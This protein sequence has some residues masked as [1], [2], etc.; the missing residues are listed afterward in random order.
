MFYAPEFFHAHFLRCRWKI[1]TFAPS[2]YRSM[3]DT[4]YKVAGHVFALCMENESSVS[5]NDMKQ[6]EPFLTEPTENVPGTEVDPNAP[7]WGDDY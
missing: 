5:E 3:N 7:G 4:Y 2:F 6:Y 1:R